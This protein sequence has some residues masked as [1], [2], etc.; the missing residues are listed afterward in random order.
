VF[1]RAT[2]IDGACIDSRLVLPGQLFVPI[3]A[4]R[5]GHDYIGAAV[6]AGAGA[7]LTA[8][9]LEAGTAIRVA[10][11]AAPSSSWGVRRATACPTG[12]SASRA[13][14]ARPP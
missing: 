6:A 12:W 7:Y 4:E 10:D 5:D 3:V 9:P 8:G 1:G 13:A 2:E 11:T 14:W